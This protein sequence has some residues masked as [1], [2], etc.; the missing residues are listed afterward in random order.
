MTDATVHVI[1]DDPR[2]LRAITRLLRSYDYQVQIYSS[3]GEFLRQKLLSSTACLVLDLK[4][5]EMSGLNVQEIL[6]QGDDFLPIIFVSG[7]ADVA[8]SVQAMKGGAIDFL[9]KPFN[10]AELIS[11]VEKA[12]DRSRN[13]QKE[14]L[15]LTRDREAFDTLTP[16]EREVCLGI[17]Q[18]LLNKQVGFELGTTEKT[19]KAQ[20]ARVMQKLGAGSLADVVR[21]VERLRTAGAIPVTAEQSRRSA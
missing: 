19:V 20:R 5:P 9:I 3:A 12:L 17:A 8:S 6:A 13:A 11:A 2:M 4:M 18:G 14:R 16:R 1:D 15:I 10:E 21:L 7:H